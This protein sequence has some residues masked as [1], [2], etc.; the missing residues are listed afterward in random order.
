M[1][2]APSD[3]MWAALGAIAATAIT[4]LSRLVR[5]RR[6]KPDRMAAEREL[7]DE[8]WARLDQEKRELLAE[9]RDELKECR[10]R[11]DDLEALVRAERLR[12]ALLIRA[13]QEAG[14][15]VPPAAMLEID[16]DPATGRY[17]LREVV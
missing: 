7:L 13:L 10:D 11:S 1:P 5:P 6:P 3:G 9:V 4:Q 12:V 16:F 17:Q 15:P 2:A 14:I 8:A